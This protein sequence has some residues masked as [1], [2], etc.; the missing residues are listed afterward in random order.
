MIPVERKSLVSLKFG[1]IFMKCRDNS[2]F[3]HFS[4]FFYFQQTT[5]VRYG[6]LSVALTNAGAVAHKA[7]CE[8]EHIFRVTAGII[9][10]L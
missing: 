2:F 8:P 1:G 3:F 4:F 7:E 9:R 10:P 5:M 6:G